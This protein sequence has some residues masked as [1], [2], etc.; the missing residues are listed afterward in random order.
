MKRRELEKNLRKLGWE[1]AR[2][3]SKHDVWVRGERELTVPRHTEINEYT[4][5]AILRQARRNR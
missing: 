4:A 5:M 3:G 2:H 1:L